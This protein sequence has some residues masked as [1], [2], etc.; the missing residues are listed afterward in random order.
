MK[1]KV[2]IVENNSENRSQEPELE[3]TEETIEKPWEPSVTEIM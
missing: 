3:K 1:K 2:Q